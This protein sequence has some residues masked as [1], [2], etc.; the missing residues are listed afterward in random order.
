[1]TVITDVTSAMCM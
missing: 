1:V